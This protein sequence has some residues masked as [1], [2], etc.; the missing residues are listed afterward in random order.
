L[1]LVN[2]TVNVVP[3]IG[4]VQEEL[5]PSRIALAIVA[6]VLASTLWPLATSATT[7]PLTNTPSHATPAACKKWAAKQDEDAIYMWSTQEDGTYPR[8]VGLKRLYLYCL[9]HKPPPD[10]TNFGS[11][12][13][14]DRDY[15]AA[16]PGIKLCKDVPKE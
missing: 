10:I 15:C 4:D 13:G 7:P 9:G 12:A 14:F 8:D 16:H 5:M 11:S 1:F 6:T 3:L 2:V